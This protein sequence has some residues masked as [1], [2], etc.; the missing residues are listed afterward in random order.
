MT[1]STHILKSKTI[2]DISIDYISTFI[3]LAGG[4]LIMI[5]V[6]RR[7]GVESYGILISLISTFSVITAFVSSNNQSG[8]SRYIAIY[9]SADVQTKY[10]NVIVFGILVDILTLI[11]IISIIYFLKTLS[12]SLSNKFYFNSEIFNVLVFSIPFKILAGTFRGILIGNQKFKIQ[13]LILILA[14]TVKFVLIFFTAKDGLLPVAFSYLISDILIFLGFFCFSI[15]YT[16]FNKVNWNDG[17]RELLY[18]NKLNFISS[19][20]KSIISKADIILLNYF[21]NALLVGQYETT[22]K[23]F[24]PLTHVGPS[25][26]RIIF[27]KFSQYSFNKNLFKVKEIILK[28]SKYVVLASVFYLFI[29]ISFSDYYFDY[30]NLEQ[31]FKVMSVIGVYYL[32]TTSLWWGS[33]Y[34]QNFDLAYT[35]KTNI[36]FLLSTILFYPLF[37]KNVDDQ[38]FAISIAVLI[39]YLPPYLLGVLHFYKSISK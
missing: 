20:I 8:V 24:I 33:S 37:L 36:I 28:G 15:K 18:F 27:P 3:Q 22:K 10:N 9:K 2:K 29:V 16:D 14:V 25:I 34:F 26:N 6:N 5:I 38:L 11:L 21:S 31:N 4:F 39:S 7:L 12:P 35:I 1:L 32:L 30:Q 23:L 13:S 19:T 17:Y